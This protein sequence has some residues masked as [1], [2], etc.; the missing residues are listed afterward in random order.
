MLNGYSFPKG[1][2]TIFKYMPI[3]RF[4]ESVD[5]RELVF[6]SPE[7]WYDPFE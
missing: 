5:N 6:V 4:I 1:K 3:D 7:M 2:K